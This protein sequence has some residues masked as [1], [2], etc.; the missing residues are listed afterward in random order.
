[1][2]PAATVPSGIPRA[3]VTV[4]RLRPCLPQST[5]LRPAWSPP[6]GGFDAAVH[7]QVVQF[8][9][10]HAVV[11]A[12]D[13]QLQRGEQPC[14]DPLVAPVAEGG[15]RA[16]GI[17]DLAVAT[18]EH[19]DL[20]ELIE[21]YPVGHAAPVAAKRV[22]G[23]VGTMFGQQGSELVPQ[24]GGEPRWKGRHEFSTDQEALARS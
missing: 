14:G 12:Q 23:V 4:E 10:D 2:A 24:G 22:V 5:G 15:G 1:L 20:G 9:A 13:Q 19:Q 7:G 8:Q 17:G 16:G 18:A 21:D 11:G 6:Q 3:S